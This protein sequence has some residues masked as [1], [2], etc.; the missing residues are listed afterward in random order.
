MVAEIKS[1]FEDTRNLLQQT[2]NISNSIKEIR[3]KK[4]NEALAAML[5]TC[6]ADLMIFLDFVI[7]VEGCETDSDIEELL[8]SYL[9]PENE[10][11]VS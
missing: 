7:E 1:I 10:R 5:K 6:Q 9:V 11:R 3:N 4:L 2:E 8:E